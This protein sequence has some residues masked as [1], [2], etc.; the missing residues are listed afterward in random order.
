[1]QGLFSGRISSAFQLSWEAAMGVAGLPGEMP[2]GPGPRDLLSHPRKPALRPP[3]LTCK[4]VIFLS[5][6]MGDVTQF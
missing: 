3:S 1:M 4:W 6:F 5:M 2:M